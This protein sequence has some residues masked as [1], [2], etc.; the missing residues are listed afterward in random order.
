MGIRCLQDKKSLVR[1]D[2]I[3]PIQEQTAAGFWKVTRTISNLE[4][5]SQP[6]GRPFC[7][8]HLVTRLAVLCNT[9]RRVSI[10]ARP[11]ELTILH[12]FHSHPVRSPLGLEQVGMAFGTSEQFEMN[13]VREGYVACVLILEKNVAGSG[14]AFDAV[15]G[16]VESLLAIMAGPAG[17]SVFHCF[18]ADVIAI[19]LLFEDL[20][21]T[22]ITGKQAAMHIM[23]EDNLADRFGLYM[24]LGHHGPHA[25]STHFSHTDSIQH[26]G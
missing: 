1:I 26:G 18:H 15:A 8:L 6:R 14:M 19:A 13:G 4:M 12:I 17:L 7:A 16:Y 2:L 22:R 23:I 21:V 3:L 11:A 20:G 9:E 5:P 25:H 10:M 24:N